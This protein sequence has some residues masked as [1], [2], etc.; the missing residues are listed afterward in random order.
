[1]VPVILIPLCSPETA[2]GQIRS[3]VLWLGYNDFQ[4][5]HDLECKD[6]VMTTCG[7]EGPDGGRPECSAAASSGSDLNFLNSGSSSS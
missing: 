1:M 4:Q 6:C 7:W 3:S 5:A 2:S